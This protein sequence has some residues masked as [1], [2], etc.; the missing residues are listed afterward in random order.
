MTAPAPEY[1]GGHG[2]LVGKTV[3]VTA[4][5]GLVRSSCAARHQE[6]AVALQPI[7]EGQQSATSKDGSTQA[8][9]AYL[10]DKA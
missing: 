10:L 4:A 7:L 8:L 2:L 3:V 1:V 5:A 9:I 6:L